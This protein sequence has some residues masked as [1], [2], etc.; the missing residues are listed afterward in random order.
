MHYV[1]LTEKVV[2]D[3]SQ[4]NP[5]SI[6]NASYA[7]QFIEA[8]DEVTFGWVLTEKGWQEPATPTPAQI[9]EENKQ[10][11]SMLLQETDW[12]TIPDVSNPEL[13]NPY[14]MNSTEFA[15]YRSQVRQ[16]AVNPPSTLIENWPAKP[17]EAWSS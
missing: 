9:K 12:T 4:V 15:I 14:L 3:Q 16:I 5:F 2:T 11:A 8:P 1:Y 17:T 7:A 6:F 13:S 10:Q